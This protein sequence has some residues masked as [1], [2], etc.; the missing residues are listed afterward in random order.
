MITAGNN[1]E[2][3]VRQRLGNNATVD[4]AKRAIEGLTAAFAD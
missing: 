4:D 2:E 3:A 1:L